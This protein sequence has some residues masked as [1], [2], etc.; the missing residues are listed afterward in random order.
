MRSKSTMVLFIELIYK[1]LWLS[2]PIM[3]YII[4]I[5]VSLVEGDC[6]FAKVLAKAFKLANL[7]EEGVLFFT[8][9]L[10]IKV[11]LMELPL[12]V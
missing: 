12:V 4:F 8:K 2:K 5:I 3:G 10:V 11:V 9:R 1:I 7:L 6:F